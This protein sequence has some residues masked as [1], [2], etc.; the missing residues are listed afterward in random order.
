MAAGAEGIQLI[1]KQALLPVRALLLH[2]CGYNVKL[3]SSTPSVS[4]IIVSANALSN[5]AIMFYI[6]HLVFKM[7]IPVFQKVIK[8]LVL[9][10]QHPLTLKR[11]NRPHFSFLFVFLPRL[12]Y[13]SML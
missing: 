5:L 4:F 13:V 8:C 1:L 2:P 6:N 11:T 9:S 3:S 7:S 10:V 12:G